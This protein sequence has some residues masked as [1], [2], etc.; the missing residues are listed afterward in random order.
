MVLHMGLN[1]WS[2]RCLSGLLGSAA[3]RKDGKVCGSALTYGASPK[4]PSSA[5]GKEEG[6]PSRSHRAPVIFLPLVGVRVVPQVVG[7]NLQR[8]GSWRES[9]NPALP[10]RFHRKSTK[11]SDL[12]TQEN[13]L[14]PGCSI[15]LCRRAEVASLGTP[16]GP[17]P[18]QF[19]RP[20]GSSET[21]RQLCR[22]ILGPRQFGCECV[23][24]AGSPFQETT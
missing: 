8:T 7:R 14:S 4:G 6:Q 23:L 21:G 22:P 11:K 20:E 17:W 9:V 2:G 19:P 16:S 18:G 12:C 3:S 13:A 1:R 24:G 5:S 10:H 15:A